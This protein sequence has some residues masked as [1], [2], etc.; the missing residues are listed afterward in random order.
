MGLN[1][2]EAYGQTPLEE[3]EKEGFEQQ[4]SEDSDSMNNV[5]GRYKENLQKGIIVAGEQTDKII[6]IRHSPIKTT[7]FI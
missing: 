3:E 2:N 5:S 4:N 6:S 1:L 7:S